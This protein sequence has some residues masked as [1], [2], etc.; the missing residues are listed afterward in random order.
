MSLYLGVTSL[1]MIPAAFVMAPAGAIVGA[2]SR[3][4]GLLITSLAIVMLVSSPGFALAAV[5]TGHVSR[6]RHPSA[7]FGRAGLIC[8]YVALGG[9]VVLFLVSVLTWM[10]IGPAGKAS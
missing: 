1:A 5:V 4:A 2:A 7:G 8:G 9:A 3:S 6:R 10:T